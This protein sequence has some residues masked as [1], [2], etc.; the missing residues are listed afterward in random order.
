MSNT[1]MTTLACC[2]LAG[3]L[4]TGGDVVRAQRIVSDD[5]AAF[6]V[7][8]VRPNTSGSGQRSAG[9]QPGGRFTARNMTLRGLLAAAHGTPQPLPLYRVVGGPGW[10]DT[11]RFDIDARAGAD[12]TDLP[13]KPGWSPRGQQMLRALLAER[14]RL[15]TRQEMRELP[16]YALVRARTDGRLG[17]QLV[18]SLDD[19]CSSAS[20]ADTPGSSADPLPCGGFRFTPPEHVSGRHLTMDEIARF[21]MLNAVDR[22]VSN[23]TGLSGHFNMDLEFT[24]DVPLPEPQRAVG[25]AQ[26]ASRVGTSIFTAVQEQ[27]GLKLEATRSQLEVVVIDSVARLEPD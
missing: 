22:P 21:I 3:V 16:S 27:L 1:F 8:S 7:A 12:L 2:F 15:V 19:E 23:G 13:G 5:A 25:E 20:P 18:V 14:F 24:R 10:M 11:D 26:P 6:E 4:A 17:S 9:F